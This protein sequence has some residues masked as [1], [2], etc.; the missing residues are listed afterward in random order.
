MRRL[1]VLIADDHKGLLEAVRTILNS[2]MEIIASVANGESLFGLAMELQP[3]IIITDISMP[4]LSGIN[5]ANRLRESSCQSK[6]IFL[7]VHTD[8]D[9]VRTALKTGALGYVVKTSISTDLLFAIREAFQGRTFVS[10]E[11]SSE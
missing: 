2:E 7:T 1:R 11:A 3:D 5:V 9:V 10:P 4:K 8:P 6:I